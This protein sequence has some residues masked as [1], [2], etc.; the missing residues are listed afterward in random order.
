M[1]TLADVSLNQ[2]V[3]IDEM[4]LENDLKHRLQDLGMI[5]GSKV[6]V[7]NHSGEN[8]IVLLHNTRLALSQ[9]LLK[10]ILVKDLTED[11]EAWVPLDQLRVGEQGVVVNVHG[12]GAV[13]RRLMDMGLT[14]GTQVKVVK[15][16]PLGDPIELRVRGYELSLRKSESEMVVVSKEAE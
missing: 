16:A 10:K 2:V 11:Q 12:T 3:Q 1:T 4:T 9:S 7:V 13:K 15:L 5:V 8:G 14:K 6:A